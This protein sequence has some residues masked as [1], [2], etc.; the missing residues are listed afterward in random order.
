MNEKL[1]KIAIST[2]FLIFEYF[3]REGDVIQVKR[4]LHNEEIYKL[5]VLSVNWNEITFDVLE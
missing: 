3:V 1:L 4:F 2:L 5:K